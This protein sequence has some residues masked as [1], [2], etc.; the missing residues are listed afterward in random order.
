MSN[1]LK[2]LRESERYSQSQ[3]SNLIG[4]RPNTVWRWENERAK[5]DLDTFIKIAKALNTSVAYLLGETN[6][7]VPM[8]A[9]TNIAQTASNS[10]IDQDTQNDSLGDADNSAATGRLIYE[11]GET[12]RI[13]IHDTPSNQTCFRELISKTITGDATITSYI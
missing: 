12:H 1:R 3:F 13:N 6:A 4:V 10:N 2:T 5:P 7:P 11:W 8:T 9:S